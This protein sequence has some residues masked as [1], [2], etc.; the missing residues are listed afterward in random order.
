MNEADKVRLENLQIADADGVRLC[1][2]DQNELKRL[3]R[4]NY[5]DE[6]NKP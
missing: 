2:A 3:Q 4:E 5:E 1:E 6:Q